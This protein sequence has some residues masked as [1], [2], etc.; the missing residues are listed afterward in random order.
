MGAGASAGAYDPT[1]DRWRVIAPAPISPTFAEAIW[2]GDEMMVFGGVS[3]GGLRNL[4]DAAAYNPV[5]KTWR[6]LA[7]LPY[8]LE[9]EAEAVLGDGVVY[10]WPSWFGHAEATPAPL[11]YD[12]DT[13]SWQPLLTPE[14]LDTPASP[15]LVWTGHELLAW[16]LAPSFDNDQGIG[17]A[18]EPA[19]GT[20]RPLPAAPLEPTRSEDGNEASQ[21]ATWTGSEMVVWTGWIGTEWEAPTT[22]IVA[23]DPNTQTWR[24]LD[25]APVPSIGLWHRPLIWTGTQLLVY[26]ERVLIY[27]P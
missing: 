4:S 17:V 12:L 26:G 6:S 16:G 10:A 9:R 20:W 21:A 24:H 1:W 27:T 2:T 14:G 13:D 3:Q 8:G 22:L 5:T 19:T 7:D 11:A 23:Y 18:F 25:P 15:S